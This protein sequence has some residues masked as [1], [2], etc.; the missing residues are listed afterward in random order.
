M[1]KSLNKDFIIS[2]SLADSWEEARKEWNEVKY[3]GDEITKCSL[4]NNKLKHKFAIGRYNWAVTIEPV[5]SSCV[6]KFENNILN[7][8]LKEA[9]K[10]KKKQNEK[11]KRENLLK[12]NKFEIDTIDELKKYFT[13]EDIEEYVKKGY[14]KKD[15]E[16]EFDPLKDINLFKLGLGSKRERSLVYDNLN[17]IIYVTENFLIPE[18]RQEFDTESYYRDL[19]ILEEAYFREKQEQEEARRESEQLEA[20]KKQE[21][22]EWLEGYRQRE[23]ARAKVKY[24]SLRKQIQELARTYDLASR[25]WEYVETNKDSL[26]EKEYTELIEKTLKKLYIAPIYRT[27]NIK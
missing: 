4:C 14:F 5:G 7:K 19:K 23:K 3:I 16:N 22:R 13:I 27:I 11:I 21:Q 20:Y 26:S 15:K 1:A 9:S 2:M 17:R 6:K 24:D 12:E 25:C 10:E 8:G 18:I